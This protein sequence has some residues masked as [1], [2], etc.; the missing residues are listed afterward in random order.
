MSGEA[1]LLV[2]DQSVFAKMLMEV[3]QEEGYAVTC[4]G[5]PDQAMDTIEASGA[6]FDALVADIHL[7][8]PLDGLHVAR[9][10]RAKNPSVSLVFMSGEPA[11]QYSSH[12]PIRSRFLEKP[13]T[14]TELIVALEKVLR[15]EG[16]W[17]A[18]PQN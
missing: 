7:G 6:E 18:G 13:F 11:L 2:E 5:D 1:V 8:G 14:P 17:R 12:A 4:T 15:A 10:L 16:A 9:A 3:L